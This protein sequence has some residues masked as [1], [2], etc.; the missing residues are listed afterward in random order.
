MKTA[1]YVAT[2][3]SFDSFRTGVTDGRA[4][5]ATFYLYG[6]VLVPVFLLVLASG[7]IGEF[8]SLGG[9]SSRWELWHAAPDWFWT[10]S[11][12]FGRGINVVL[13]VGCVYLVYR[14]GARTR[15]RQTGRYAAILLTLSLG[16]IAAAHELAEDVPMLFCFLLA[17]LLIIRY[18]ETGRGSTLLLGSFFGGLAIAFKLTGGVAAV[19]L[20]VAII[21][22]TLRSTDGFRTALEPRLYAL[23]FVVG[24]GAVYVGIPSAL[25][26]GPEALLTRLTHTTTRKTTAL[27]STPPISYWMTL[28]YVKSLGVPLFVAC[29]CGVAATVFRFGRSRSIPDHELLLLVA[30]STYVVVF[31]Q[32][33]FVRM[34]HLLPTIPLL[35]L[36]LAPRLARL[37]NEHG[38]T[39]RVVV[40]LLLLSTA[41][42][43]VAGDAK[44]AMDRR[45]D[46]TGWM[47]TEFGEN[48]SVLVYENSIADVAAVHGRP[49][50]H[51]E[52]REENATYSSSLVLNETAY[53]EW[54]VST[55]QRGPE[56]IQLTS[57]DLAY[58]SP[59]SARS[60][61]YPRRAEYIKTLVDGDGYDYTVAREFGDRS[62]EK[63][64][65]EERIL[66]AAIDPDVP[67]RE[68]YVLLLERSEE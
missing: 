18:V 20:G 43:A 61:Q 37:R 22:R 51:Y 47:A 42:F 32:W 4:L 26:G 29:L 58:L 17:L 68:S 13:A 24:L 52:Y 25:V 38:A 39:G 63:E 27:Q 50:T 28:Q 33:Q 15:T 54:M 59:L 1:G 19:V 7:R 66:R 65:L 40:A 10:L 12:L 31:S 36:L 11:I 8:V 44:Y 5:G 53:T 67:Q 9:L 60:Y 35:L 62:V 16:F 56:Y 57:S 30:L 14:I 21:V 48:E 64:S 41:M 3:P 2:D 34:H 45:D 55:P 46:A 6:I 23:C 49:V